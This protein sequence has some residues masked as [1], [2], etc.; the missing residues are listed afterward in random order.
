MS[1]VDIN[2]LNIEERIRE[3]YTGTPNDFGQIIYTVSQHI[4]GTGESSSKGTG[5]SLNKSTNNST[6]NAVTQR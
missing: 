3:Y 1:S 5:K 2:G 6:T 4:L